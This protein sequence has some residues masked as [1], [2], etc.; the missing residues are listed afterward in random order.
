MIPSRLKIAY[1]FSGIVALLAFVAA[2]GGIFLHGL[3]RDN[4]FVKA[5]WYGNDLV[6]LF[7]IAPMLLGALWLAWRG[8]ARALLVWMGLL[9][10]VSYNYAFYLFGAAFNA[11]FLAYL[12]LFALPLYAIAL[13]IFEIDPDDIGSNF[14]PRTP[15]KWISVFLMVIA[16]PLAIVEIGQI[17]TFLFSG[18]LP[19]TIVDTGHPTG[20]VY[21]LDLSFV[22]PCLLLAAVL[23]WQRRPWGYMLG[24]MMLTKGFTYGLV[25]IM[26]A[27]YIAGFSLQGKWDPLTPFYAFIA[28]GSF[29][30]GLALLW[31]GR[32]GES[33][34][35]GEH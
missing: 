27:A 18:V 5:A 25:L 30:G 11:F 34:G 6:T 4:E 8:S 33:E 19:Q 35:G 13:A 3:Y 32:E 7:V 14:G 20:V 24:A 21:A 10:C 31:R 15:V 2:G 1:V 26:S 12:A 9:V 29:I 23:L 16:I 28:V 22:I 17:G